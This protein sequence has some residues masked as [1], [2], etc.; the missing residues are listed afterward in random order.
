ML[1]DAERPPCQHLSHGRAIIMS[2]S[3]KGLAM[4]IFRV[5]AVVWVDTDEPG[6]C[7]RDH[8]QTDLDS[9]VL[10]WEEIPQV[11]TGVDDA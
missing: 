8:I 10:L 7:A 9:Q 3:T 4:R 11:L 6:A 1:A 5:H 2:T